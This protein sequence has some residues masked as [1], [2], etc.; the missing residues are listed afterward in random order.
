MASPDQP[1]RVVL[2]LADDPDAMHGTVEHADGRREPFWG[3]LDL[4]SAL[5]RC[6]RTADGSRAADR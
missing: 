5:E 3:W 1:V 2:E 4:M 6:L